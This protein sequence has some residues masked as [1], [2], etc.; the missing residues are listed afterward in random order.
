MVISFNMGALLSKPYLWRSYDN[1]PKPSDPNDQDTVE[2]FCVS[3]PGPAHREF[4]WQVARAT[5]AAPGYFESINLQD[6][7]CLDGG[8]V[9]NNPALLAA[10]E[11]YELHNPPPAFFVSIGTGLKRDSDQADK[12]S[13]ERQPTDLM[14]R[15]QRRKQSIN[16]WVKIFRHGKNLMVSCEGHMGTEGW[17]RYYRNSDLTPDRM[18]RLNVE[19]ASLCKDIRLDDWRPPKTGEATLEA[20]KQKTDAY[21]SKEE[22]KRDIESIAQRAVDIRRERAKTERWEAFAV[23]LE[24]ICRKCGR[25]KRYKDRAGLRRH[26]KENPEHWDA[27]GRAVAD[28]DTNGLEAELNQRR[29]YTRAGAQRR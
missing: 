15:N 12:A 4:I 14:S 22:V 6:H 7:E 20:I 27:T 21:L 17:R 3:N 16:K 29:R 11:I 26:L 9:A 24:Y 28:D 10:Q 13:P 5:T 25:A 19:D 8:M 18:Y 2:E 23:D 1:D